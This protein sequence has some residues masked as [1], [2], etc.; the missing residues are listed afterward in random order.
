MLT[1]LGIV[2]VVFGVFIC[3]M[4]YSVFRS[5][6]PLWGFVLGGF[7]G[8]ILLPTFI[9]VTGVEEWVIEVISFIVVGMIG[10]LIAKPLYYVVVFL[11]GAAMGGLIGM[12]LGAYL[13]VSNGAV[14]VHALNRLASMTFPPRIETPVQVI[15]VVVLALAVGGFAISFQKFMITASTAFLGSAAIISGMT[16]AILDILRSGANNGILIVA[17]W[18]LLG[19]I[20]IFVQFRMGDET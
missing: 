18:L 20:G 19:M 8:I 7:I 10:A 16:G 5:M 15:L 2:S 4:G 17:G 1:P 3:F 9:H 6:L 12:V 11:S 14:S 13:D